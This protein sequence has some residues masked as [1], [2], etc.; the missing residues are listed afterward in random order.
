ME[1]L[2]EIPLILVTGVFAGFLNTVAG[3]GSLLSLPVLIFLGLPSAVANGTNRVA[4]FIQNAS[5]ITG[6][7]RKG[8]SDFAY[9]ALL[10]LPALVG[11][12]IGAGIAIEMDQALFN[13]ILSGIMIVVLL[14][15]LF[16][17]TK[18]L[19]GGAENLSL[20]RK[21][22]GMAAFFLVGI[23]GGFIQAGVGFIVIAALTLI[24]GF[25]LV[26]TNAIKVFVIFFYTIIA[27]IVFIMSG[28]VSWPLG[29]TLAVG[30]ATGAWIGSHWAVDKGEK[31]IRVVLVVTVLAF[32]IRLFWQT[33]G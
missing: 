15:T 13:R 22:V 12:W 14:T 5:A 32:A 4:V 30:N 16:S 33:L 27:L 23:Y 31:W 1:N 19:T 11:A 21:I 17:P 2:W 8:V 18:R 7:R 24:N 10:T 20:P 6:F 29:L 28:N 9:S 26:R 3:G 25:D